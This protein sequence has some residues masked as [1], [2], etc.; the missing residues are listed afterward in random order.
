MTTE[1]QILRIV[2]SLEHEPP[3]LLGTLMPSLP[4]DENIVRY[5]DSSTDEGEHIAPADCVEVYAVDVIP[6]PVVRDPDAWAAVA[7]AGRS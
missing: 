6:A 1:K 2:V 5:F 7:K 3:L 4:D